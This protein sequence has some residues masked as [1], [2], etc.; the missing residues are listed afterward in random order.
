M[1]SEDRR[2]GGSSLGGTSTGS[3]LC[4]A[5]QRPCPLAFASLPPPHTHADC[6]QRSMLKVVGMKEFAREQEETKASK[7]DE[8]V[9][10]D[11]RRYSAWTA[12]L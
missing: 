2:G 11:H 4:P 8:A 9:E 3:A 5:Q 6:H 7:Q 1:T 12:P 10:L